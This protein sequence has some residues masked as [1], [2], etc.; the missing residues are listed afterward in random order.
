MTMTLSLTQFRF[1]VAPDGVALLTWDMPG[2]VMNIFTEDTMRELDQ[3]IDHV[4]SQPTIIGCVIASGKADSFSGGA[5][6]RMLDAI[7]ERARENEKSL[8]TEEANH[9]FFEEARK[10]GLLFRKLET[11]GKPFAIAI[12]GVCMGGATELALACHYRVLSDDAT[13]RFGLPEIKI[14]IFPGA[15]GSQRVPRLA[16]TGDALTMMLKGEALRPD[17]ALRMNLVHAVA[18]KSEMVEKAQDAI[19]AGLSPVQPWDQEKFKLPSGPVHSKAGVMIWSAANAL[20]R[21]ETYGNYPA[22]IALMKA[23]Y[24]GL[25]LPIDHALTVE[26]RYFAH[27]L[28]SQEAK[29]M[30]RS[31]FV[32]MQALNKGARRPTSEPASSLKQIGIIGAGFMGAGIATVAA[33]AG[34]DVVLIDRDQASADKGKASAAKTVASRVAKG[35]ATQEDY[36]AFVA[37]ITA[38]DDFG[39]L[40]HAD[41]VIEAVFE[42]PAIKAET[43]RKA[44]AVMRADAVFASNTSTLP[45]SEL[46]NCFS[47][48][49]DFIGIHFFSPVDRMPLVELIKGRD[50]G[51]RAVAMAFDFTRRIGKTP[52]LVNDARGFYA[53]RCV[54]NYILEGHLMLH[55]GVPPAMIE[56]VAR[57]AGMPVGPLA[58]TDE[59]AIDLIYKILKATKTALGEE[60]VDP[61][62]Y[63]LLSRLVETH[64][65]LGRKN[66][67]GFY[68]YP[69]GAAKRLW[70]GLSDFA[71][72][73]L[74]PDTLDIETLKQ[75]LLY[76]Q[77][78]EAARSFEQ[79]IVEDAREADV[80]AILGFG[81]A[82]FTGGP[83]SL[84]DGLGAAE[85]IARSESLAQRFGPRFTPPESLRAMAKHGGQFYAE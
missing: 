75:R 64:G 37:R 25:Q 8:G 5:D 1:D 20:M 34:L 57:M 35:R 9:L 7:A 60:A 83:L 81:F 77:A 38:T 15:G 69:D 44:D 21:K 54:L 68:D 46:S 42:D 17:A 51:A 50:T 4:V 73:Q 72:A 62:Q 47:R 82:P 56:N 43:I 19:R 52:I 6:I 36:D 78:L 53:N 41:L 30:I 31:L 48:P 70:K 13:T 85:F 14:G 65:R 12:H 74:D 80:G 28:K 63:D 10:L 11:C 39:R 67:K 29:A 40:A 55:E 2:R 84:I 24:E 26:A 76:S 27:V 66:G 3:V 16:P 49:R 33:L 23:V 71:T 61:V 79:G 45:I 58:L 18:S 22:A 59:V 32:S